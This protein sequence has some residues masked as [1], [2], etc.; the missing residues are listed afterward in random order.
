MPIPLYLDAARMGRMS[1]STRSALQEF[2]RFAGEYG[3]TLYF[4]NFLVKKIYPRYA[5]FRPGTKVEKIERDGSAWRAQARSL[6]GEELEIRARLIIGADGDH[7]VVLRALGERR[8]ERAHYAG[9]VRQYWKGLTGLHP[10]NLINIYLP[11]GLPLSYFYFFPLPNGEANVGYGMV[12]E[13]LA[14][15]PYK[16]RDLFQKLIREDPHLAPRFQ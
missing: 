11:K 15:Q 9:T 16:L 8:I 3:G 10:D 12:S 14:K 1:P 2:V 6:A 13:V 4:D 7:S 5:D